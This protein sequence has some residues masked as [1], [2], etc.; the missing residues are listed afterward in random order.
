MADNKRS[1]TLRSGMF[2][3]RRLFVHARAKHLSTRAPKGM[4]IHRK[5]LTTGQL[6]SDNLA[7]SV[8]SFGVMLTALGPGRSGIWETGIIK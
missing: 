8:A 2:D 7:M 3:S 5:G 6:R 4:V 1:P